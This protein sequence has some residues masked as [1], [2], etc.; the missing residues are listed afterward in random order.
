MLRQASYHIDVVRQLLEAHKAE[1][2][3]TDLVVSDLDAMV[4]NMLHATSVLEDGSGGFTRRVRHVDHTAALMVQQLV[5]AHQ[6]Q[7]SHIEQI[8]AGLDTMVS[9]IL[10]SCPPLNAPLSAENEVAYSSHFVNHTSSLA[11]TVPRA[12]SRSV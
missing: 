12:L 4:T 2:R 10:E 9:N 7:L 8:V 1:L 6:A 5:E 11:L 3:H